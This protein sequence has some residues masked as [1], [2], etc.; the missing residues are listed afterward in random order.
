MYSLWDMLSIPLLGIKEMLEPSEQVVMLVSWEASDASSPSKLITSG[1]CQ[2]FIF[3]F[4]F[5][6]TAIY[7]PIPIHYPMKIIILWLILYN[8][9]T[10]SLLS[11]R[12][13]S[14][15][16][17][18]SSASSLFSLITSMNILGFK[19]YPVICLLLMLLNRTSKARGRMPASLGSPYL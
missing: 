2:S 10:S 4:K 1:S 13:L 18:S 8:Y 17:L 14:F 3:F 9:F 7:P 16:F 12:V 15:S 11:L 5:G 6:N 19:S